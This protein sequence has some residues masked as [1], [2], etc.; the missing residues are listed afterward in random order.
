MKKFKILFCGALAAGLLAI[1]G[2]ALA[3]G[4]DNFVEGTNYVPV[5]PAQP[6]SVGPGQIEVI[7]FF[8]YG[9]PHCFGVEPYLEAWLKHKPANVVFKRIPAAWPGGEHMDVDA[10]AYYTA[11]ALGISEKIHEP[12]FNAIHLQ[13][14]YDLTNSQDALQKFFARYGVS[15]QQFDASWNSFGVQL[16][17][18]QALETLKV[19]G[20]Q[21]VPT[22]I[23]NGKWMTGAGY[24]MPYPTIVKCVE[25]LVQQ[26]EQALKK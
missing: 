10:H 3:A 21:G 4:A 16:K 19:Y 1:S 8:W 12:L 2:V 25:Y 11:Q 24:Q 6:T 23:I 13:N 5:N 20:V 26:Q 15:Q 22:F 17:M 14:Q 7:E 9:C 18:N